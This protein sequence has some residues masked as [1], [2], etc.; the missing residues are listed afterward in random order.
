MIIG[1][2]DAA[3][4]AYSAGCNEPGQVINVNGTCEITLVCLGKCYPSAS[5]T[6]AP[7]CC[8]AAG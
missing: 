8:R 2:N 7:T 1:G 5:T 3:L 6:S 4:A